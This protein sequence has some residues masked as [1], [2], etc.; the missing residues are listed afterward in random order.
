MAEDIFLPLGTTAN[1]TI[2]VGD[3]NTALAV[4]IV[5]IQNDSAGE[6]VWVIQ[7]D[8]ST[9]RVN[10]LGGSIVGDLVVVTGDLSEGD[11]VQ[12]ARESSF[13]APNPFGGGN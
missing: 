3:A 11:R 12:L 7:S 8:G 13:K 10:V 2:Q 4:P 9:V 6:Y 1:V 5:A